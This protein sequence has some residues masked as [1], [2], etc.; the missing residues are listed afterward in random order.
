MPTI[1]ALAS[2]AAISKSYNLWTSLLRSKQQLEEYVETLELKVADRTHELS[3]KNQQLQQAKAEAESANRAKSKFLAT[4]SHELRTPLNGILG[5]A[6]LLQ[7]DPDLTP[8]QLEG[9]RIID[10]SGSHLLTLINDILDLSKIEAQKTDLELRNFF[11]NDFLTEVMSLFQLK[12][13]QKGISLVLQ[14][15]EQLPASLYAD[16]IR[17]RQILL[18]LVSNAVKFTSQGNVTLRVQATPIQGTVKNGRTSSQETSLLQPYCLY[19]EV[20]DSGIGIP[21]DQIDRIFLPFEQV[22]EDLNQSNIHRSQEGT[23]LGLS[24]SQKLVELMGG[25]LKVESQMGQGSRFWFEVEVRGAMAAID[26]SLP[27]VPSAQHVIGYEGKRQKVLVIDDWECNRSLMVSL[28]QPL[29]FMV[30]TACSGQEGLAQAIEHQPDLILAD[31]VMPGIDGYEMIRQMRHHPELQDVAIIICS[32][33]PP[34]P[35]SPEHQQEHQHTGYDD[36]LVKPIQIREVLEKIQIHLGLSWVY[37]NRLDS[38]SNLTDNSAVTHF[39]NPAS[40]PSQK[41]EFPPEKELAV[42]YEAVQ[43]GH[44]KRIND[45]IERFAAMDKKYKNFVNTISK[46]ATQFDFDLMLQVLESRDN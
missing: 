46:L 19:F 28:L 18:N 25:S 30:T 24:I 2:A 36:F 39:S 8:N 22:R 11:F 9:I 16:E 23:G 33:S 37:E 29:G 12:A 6:E 38:S 15:A 40:N 44:V 7:F 14:R 17:L 31:L 45:E 41:I 21:A 42:L 34:E 10:Q 13:E 1:I 20:E 5:Y 26:L 3:Q 35:D 4:M 27:P 32:A 43:N